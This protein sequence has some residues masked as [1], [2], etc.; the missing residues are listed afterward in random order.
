M[1]TLRLLLV[2]DTASDVRLVREA[3]KETGVPVEL[4]VARDGVEAMDYLHQ[5]E[6]GMASRPDIVLLDLNLPRKNGREVLSE[7]KSSSNLKQIPV[8]VMTSSRADDDINEAY[9]LNANCYITKPNDLNEYIHI[10]RAIEDFWF[11]TATLPDNFHSG[12]GPHRRSNSFS[13]PVVS[14]AVH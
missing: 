12:G 3:L 4:S 1:K 10:I 13:Q 8:I 9:A 7:L 2:E 14:Q 11:Y 6:F 5:A